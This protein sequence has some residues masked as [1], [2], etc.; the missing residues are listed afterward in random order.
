LFC[1][2]TDSTPTYIGQL[3]R[4]EKNAMLESV[5]KVAR[6]LH[7]PF[8]VLFEG[9]IQGDVDNTVARECYEIITARPEKEQRVLLDLI[10]KIVDYKK[11]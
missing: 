4:G 9:L 7:L 1:L 5:E 8:E 11:I 2:Q 3:E 6:V 10:Q